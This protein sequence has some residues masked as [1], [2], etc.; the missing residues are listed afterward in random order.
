[1]KLTCF[2]L[3][4]CI[5][6]ISLSET[7]EK[8]TNHC[9][10][11]VKLTCFRLEFCISNISLSETPEKTKIT[12]PYLWSLP[13]LGW[14]S[15]SPRYR[16]LILQRKIH[17]SLHP[18]V[19]LTCFRLEFCISRISLSEAPENLTNHCTLLWS[20]PAI[21]WSSASP[22]SRSL[23]LHKTPQITAP[24]LWSWPALGWSSAS[25]VS[26]SLRLQK[27]HKSLHPCCEADLL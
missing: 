1:M 3:E 7:S 27:N 24:L 19:K 12:P 10:P 18:T 15:A 17:K 20:R 14:S 2:R 6:R 26:R 21:G 11:T 25:P 13:A 22:E 16:S 5:S 9:T 8:Y 4:F 23:R